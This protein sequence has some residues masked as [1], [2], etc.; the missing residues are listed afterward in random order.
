MGLFLALLHTKLS[1]I[2][3][4]GYFLM[5][6]LSYSAAFVKSLSAFLIFC[7]LGL[8]FGTFG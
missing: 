5:L 6:S 8:N 1:L 2:R 3:I 4:F 7:I